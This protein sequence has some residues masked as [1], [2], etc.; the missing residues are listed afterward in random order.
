MKDL[1]CG[2]EKMSMVDYDGKICATL[3]L[4]NCNFRC[5]FCHNSS[6]VLNYQN[7]EKY[8]IE[9]ILA[10]LNKRIGIIEAV[11]ITGGEPTIYPDLEEI[12]RKIRS[13][14][15]LIKLDT[16][17]S[18]PKVIKDL[19]NKGLIDYIAM[20]IKNSFSK[21]QKTTSIINLD[22]DKILESIDFIKQSKIDYEFRTTLVKEFHNID[23]IKEIANTLIGSKKYCLQ[24]FVDN[25]ECIS[26][27]LHKIDK[28]EVEGYKVLLE[29]YVDKVILRN[30]D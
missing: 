2:F 15:L 23:D 8:T 11:C 17:G 24:C 7:I 19:V 30:Y 16:N 21:Y 29:K 4:G 12:I 20:D 22:I 13:L 27:G 3:F 10:Y 5:P 26:S 18:N 28:E 14:G 1:I 25:G 9:E 6:L